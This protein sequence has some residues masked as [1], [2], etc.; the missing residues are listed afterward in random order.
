MFDHGIFDHFKRTSSA[1]FNYLVNIGHQSKAIYFEV[2]KTGCS[3][4]KKSLQTIELKGET[5]PKERVHDKANSPLFSL[6]DDVERT[7]EVLQNPEYVKFAFVRNPYDRI[8]S[9]YLDKIHTNM[10]EKERLSH[11]LGF[12]FEEK[13]SFL[14]FLRLVALQEPLEMDVHWKTQREL[15][16]SDLEILDY[17]GRF[18]NFQMEWDSILKR[19]QEQAAPED[20]AFFV[21]QNVLWHQTGAKEKRAQYYGIEEKKMVQKI[22]Q[23]DFTIFDYSFDL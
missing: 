5:I 14:D 10:W 20:K 7:S 13:I 17:L 21:S 9:T 11:K 2:P 15:L 12:V 19:L 18:E 6:Y 1:D 4:V 22:Y 16:P 3:T 23:E 8:L